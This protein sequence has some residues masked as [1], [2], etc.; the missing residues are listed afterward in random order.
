MN[1]EPACK[2]VRA[3]LAKNLREARNRA[4][5]SQQELANIAGINRTYLSDLEN[6]NAN[7]S[8][9]MLVKITEGLGIPFLSL[10]E[11]VDDY[12]T[13]VREYVVRV[14]P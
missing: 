10:F 9:D 14:K 6:E 2:R 13:E 11:G 7:A 5:Y 4:H 8:V 1:H 3:I 12:P